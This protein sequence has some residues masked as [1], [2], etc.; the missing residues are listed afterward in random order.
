MVKF[1]KFAELYF[2][3]ENI[4]K[5]AI[6]DITKAEQNA[7][8]DIEY[9]RELLRDD[10]ITEKGFIAEQ[11]RI[12]GKLAALKSAVS[13]SIKELQGRFN[14]AVDE[15]TLPKSEQ[16]DSSIVNLLESVVL[17]PEEFIVYTQKYAGNPT[18]ERVL[19]QYRTDKGISVFWQCESGEK[20]K[21]D[22]ETLISVLE[23]DISLKDKD[24]ISRFI[25]KN[26]H[27]LRCAN[28]EH[29]VYESKTDDDE[30]NT[31]NIVLI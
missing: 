30:P 31:N 12:N 21:S 10:E 3:L 29:L 27:S 11:E 8:T 13:S 14:S 5:T 1:D 20:I 24:A 15:Y 2:E 26:Y 9:Q 28:P 23:S 19:E 22:F 16:L 4:C 7:K 25:S 18:M 17:S 6:D